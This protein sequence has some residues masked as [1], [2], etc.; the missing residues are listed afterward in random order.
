LELE[1]PT[2]LTALTRL[3]GTIVHIGLTYQEIISNLRKTNE[4]TTSIKDYLPGYQLTGVHEESDL[5][6]EV[7]E[8]LEFTDLAKVSSFN[9]D[10]SWQPPKMPYRVALFEKHHLQRDLLEE[11]PV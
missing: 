1:D 10:I 9:R 3:S 6:H 7:L 2:V 11:T 8:E 4:W 5:F